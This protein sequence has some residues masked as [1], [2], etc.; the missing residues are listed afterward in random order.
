MNFVGVN[1]LTNE[2]V[3]NFNVFC[4]SMEYS[5][6]GVEMGMLK[7]CRRRRSQMISEEV[8]A[9]ARYSA[10]VDERATVGCFLACQEMRLGPRKMQNPVVDHLSVESPAQSKSLQPVR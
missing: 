2:V 5:F 10:S 6:V 8:V 9:R 4:L 7:F 1:F 3:V